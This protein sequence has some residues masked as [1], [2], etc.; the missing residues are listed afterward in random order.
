MSKK[1]FNT[2]G[3]AALAV[4]LLALCAQVRVSAQDKSNDARSKQDTSSG[5]NGNEGLVGSWNVQVTIRDCQ[6]GAT[7]VTFPA[8]ITY[9]Q[10]GTMQETANDATPLLRLPGHGVWSHQ[11]RR[12]YSR[13][14]QFFRYNA[15][16]TYAG[17]AKIN[18]QI[19]L[20]RSGSSYNATGVFEFF[21]PNGNSIVSGCATETATRFE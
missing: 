5:Q 18:V 9:N 21:D 17:T 16:R 4:L 11:T 7:F 14:F 10:G 13:A 20:N 1:S 8:M 6:T 2:I 15:D 12:T 3:A 19:E